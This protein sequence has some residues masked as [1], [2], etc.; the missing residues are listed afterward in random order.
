MTFNPVLSSL[1]TYNFVYDEIPQ[2]KLLL[3]NAWMTGSL[4]LVDPL[5]LLALPVR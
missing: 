4:C 5:F 3:I 1:M 2:L